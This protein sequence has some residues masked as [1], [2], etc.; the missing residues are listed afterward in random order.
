MQN[1]FTLP[2]FRGTLGNVADEVFIFG[3]F[4]FLKSFS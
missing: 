3:L 1:S 2:F 4:P